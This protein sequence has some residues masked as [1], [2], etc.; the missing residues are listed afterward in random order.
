MA[1][2]EDVL[3]ILDVEHL[4]QLREL[5]EDPEGLARLIRRYLASIDVQLE[6]M[7]ELLAAGNAEALE[8]AAHGLAG[9]SAVYGLPRVSSYSRALVDRARSRRLEGAQALLD[10]LARAFQEARPRLL[11]ELSIEA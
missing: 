9:S 6:H 8:R 10:E 5:G 4:T 2:M 7:R 11:A 1:L 3:P